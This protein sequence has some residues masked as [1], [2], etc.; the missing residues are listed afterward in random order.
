MHLPAQLT[1]H[2]ASRRRADRLD[3]PPL[4]PD[5]DPLLGLALHPDQRPYARQ[6]LSRLLDLLDER[7]EGMGSSLKVRLIAASRISSA[8]SSCR[9]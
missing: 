4:S 6:T 9:G 8:S 5:D 1:L 2:L 3:H 7:L